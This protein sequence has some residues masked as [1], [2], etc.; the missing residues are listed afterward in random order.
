MTVDQVNK[1]M[2]DNCVGQNFVLTGDT[3]EPVEALLVSAVGVGQPTRPGQ[4]VA[5]GE[6]FSLVFCAPADRRLGQGLYQVEH[7]DVG[8]LQIFMVPIG[9]DPQ[10]R[11]MRLEA[12]FNFGPNH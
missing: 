4:H 1:A 11:G 2:F 3:G 6:A 8:R 7:A 10:G 9:P 5:V 12:V